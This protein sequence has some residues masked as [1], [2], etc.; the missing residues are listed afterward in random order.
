[1]ITQAHLPDKYRVMTE[2]EQKMLKEGRPKRTT[3]IKLCDVTDPGILIDIMEKFDMLIPRKVG[4][5]GK[6]ESPATEV[7]Y[8]LPCLLKTVPEEEVPA[9]EDESV[10]TLHFKCIARDVMEETEKFKSA[11]LPRGFFHRL[12]SRCCRENSTWNMVK[13]YYD[14]MEFSADSGV[15][16]Y[17]RMAYNSIQLCAFKT[18]KILQNED[19]K[20]RVRSEVRENIKSMIEDI[21]KDTCPYLTHVPYLECISKSHNHR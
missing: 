3:A 16:G 1:M 19:E 21:T 6:E 10:P 18:V 4:K 13:F 8:V 5:T 17:L 9:K 7:E 2:M 14:Y 15:I 11:F 20:R 12:I